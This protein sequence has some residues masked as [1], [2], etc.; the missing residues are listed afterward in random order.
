MMSIF[1][2]LSLLQ[3]VKCTGNPW[4][5]LAVPIP[6]PTK[7]YTHA[8]GMGF[9]MGQVFCTCTQPIPIPIAGNPRVCNKIV[10][11][12]YAIPKF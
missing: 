3:L 9:F 12:C 7:T 4:V 10:K 8:M 11:N 6:I 2:C 1:Y 5:F